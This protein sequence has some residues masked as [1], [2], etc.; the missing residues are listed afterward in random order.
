MPRGG[1]IDPNAG[2]G[3]GGSKKRL[4]FP[5]PT[6]PAKPVVVSRVVVANGGTRLSTFQGA[7]SKAGAGRSASVGAA[8]RNKAPASSQQPPQK[9]AKPAQ[10]KGSQPPTPKS[11][12]AE[13]EAPRRRPQQPP[14]PSYDYDE[15]EPAP[16]SPPPPPPQP[17]AA[18]PAAQHSP[19]R[20]KAGYIVEDAIDTFF[21]W[22]KGGEKAQ[23]LTFFYSVLNLSLF[24]LW[25]GCLVAA[26]RHRLWCATARRAGSSDHLPPPG[27]GVQTTA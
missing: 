4:A 5:P 7:P 1:I 16:A 20:K 27:F 14:Q 17:A 2:G 21:A 8:A 15:P 6:N 26:K 9:Q 10:S 3:G 18:A 25:F 12:A 24:S 23:T 13:Q 19:K 22:G 11:V